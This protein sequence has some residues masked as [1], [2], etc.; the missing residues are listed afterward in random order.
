MEKAMN[1]T[2]DVVITRDFDA[3]REKVWQMWSDCAMVMRWWGPKGFTSPSCEIDFRVG[4]K[5][6]FCMRA[7]AEQGGG[8]FYSTGVYQNI[9]PFE[10][11]VVTDSFADEDG[12]VVPATYYGMQEMPL[13]LLVTIRFEDREGK[14]RMTLRHAG[15]PAGELLEMTTAGWNESFDKLDAVLAEG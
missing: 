12:N 6:V 7:P 3:S 15:L 4:G 13:E 8:D 5:N 9:T 10:E 14:T 11:I 2:K 1:E